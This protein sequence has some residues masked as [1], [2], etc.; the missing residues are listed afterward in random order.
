LL[1][2]LPATETFT[3]T[4]ITIQEDYIK[5]LKD[6]DLIKK[7]MNQIIQAQHRTRARVE[8]VLQ[9]MNEFLESFDVTLAD[10]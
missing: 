10:D 6:D 8:P 5:M 4:S 9:D 7:T 3:D 2:S 1:F